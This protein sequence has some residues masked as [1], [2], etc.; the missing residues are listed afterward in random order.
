MFEGD[1]YGGDR[2]LVSLRQMLGEI[3]QEIDFIGDLEAAEVG[4]RRRWVE[5]DGVRVR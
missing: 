1:E 3:L 5:K 2:S 4:Q